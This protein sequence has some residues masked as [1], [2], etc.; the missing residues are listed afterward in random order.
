MA[1]PG[2][3]WTPQ[4]AWNGIVAPGVFGAAGDGIKIRLREGLG[5]A[6]LI[7]SREQEPA[8]GRAF[9]SRLGL[10]LPTR[11][12]AVSSASHTLVWAGPG[13]WLLVAMAHDGFA[14]DCASLTAHAAVADQSDGRAVLSL[15]GTMVR[16][17]LGKGCMVDLHPRVFPVGATALTSIAYTG[18]HLWR[19]ADGPD[20]AVYEIM[21]PR[22]MAGSFWSWLSASAAE[23]GCA[24]TTG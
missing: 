5:I 20:G 2:T 13:Q 1:E 15:S 19:S 11:P 21:V 6:S 8:L 14:E 4:S 3:A 23:F 9:E 12:V 16:K 7:A 10:S 24:I 18:V 22:S 17:V